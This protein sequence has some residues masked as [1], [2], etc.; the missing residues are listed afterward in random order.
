MLN[1]GVV[2][3]EEGKVEAEAAFDLD[4]VCDLHVRPC[5]HRYKGPT[6]ITPS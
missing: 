1:V 4:G 5:I 2:V 6:I 3:K